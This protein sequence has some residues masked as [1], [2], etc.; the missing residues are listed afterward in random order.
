M[1]QK[2]IRIDRLRYVTRGIGLGA[3]VGVLCGAS[4]AL[5]L[6][7]L[8]WATAFRNGHEYIIYTLPLAGLLIGWI[9]ERFGQ[10]IMSGNNLIIDTIHDEGPEIP[11]RMAPM[12]K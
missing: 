8:E 7:L 1:F 4:S 5:F 3:L 12:L 9:Y 2:W 10:S 11:A 6:H